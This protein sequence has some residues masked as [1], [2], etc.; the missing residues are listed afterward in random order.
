MALAATG[1]LRAGLA[2]L[3]PADATTAEAR[4]AALVDQP[5]LADLLAF[6]FRLA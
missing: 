3:C 4:R 6:T 2:A 1:D 5:A